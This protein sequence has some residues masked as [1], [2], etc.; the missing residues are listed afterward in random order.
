MSWMRTK[1][2][3]N[4]R[5]PVKKMKST[6][7]GRSLKSF[8]IAVGR[9]IRAEPHISLP[10]AS[11]GMHGKARSNLRNGLGAKRHRRGGCCLGD[12]L[13]ESVRAAKA[14]GR[15][16]ANSLAPEG[17]ACQSGGRATRNS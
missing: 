9:A 2:D 15:T 11:R 17:A 6:G 8:V 14:V 12:S 7:A 16:R 5:A 3:G 10:Y 4:T 13:S 1:G